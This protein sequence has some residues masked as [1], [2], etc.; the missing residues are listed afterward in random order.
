M[1]TFIKKLKLYTVITLPFIL[2]KTLIKV[3][4]FYIIQ[5]LRNIATAYSST[6]P[7]EAIYTE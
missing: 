3:Y 2:L 4:I 7:I 1:L 5:L 6:V